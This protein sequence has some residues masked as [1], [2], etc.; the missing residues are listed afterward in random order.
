MLLPEAGLRLESPGPI[1]T[2]LAGAGLFYRKLAAETV[3]FDDPGHLAAA[4]SV[5]FPQV[6]PLP[7]ERFFLTI[8]FQLVWEYPYNNHALFH[9]ILVVGLPG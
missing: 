3:G 1:L 8:D 7:V 4:F 9:P 2:V 6:I 5:R